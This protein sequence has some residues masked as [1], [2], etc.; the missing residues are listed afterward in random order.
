MYVGFRPFITTLGN[1]SF[2][3]D[4]AAAKFYKR[5]ICHRLILF[6]R[7]PLTRQI[8]VSLCG[9]GNADAGLKIPLREFIFAFAS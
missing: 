9:Y 4:I 1:N 3:A 5:A 7:Y 2:V 8:D 6:C